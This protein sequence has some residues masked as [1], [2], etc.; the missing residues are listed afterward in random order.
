MRIKPQR[1]PEQRTFG[2][3]RGGGGRG[4]FGGRGRGGFGSRGRGG[5]GGRDR[6]PPRRGSFGVRDRSPPRS[7][8]AASRHGRRSP[9]PGR[10]QSSPAGE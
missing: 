5:F 10:R 6:S 7:R 2:P 4:G 8:D 1:E 3:G 9:S